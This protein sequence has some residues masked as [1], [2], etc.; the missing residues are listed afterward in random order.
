MAMGG[1]ALPQGKDFA[2]SANLGFFD[3][4]QAVA[5]QAAIRLNEILYFNGG[6]GVGLSD[7]KV[8]GRVG[9]MAAW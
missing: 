6:A 5:A 9:V 7:N 8:G 4:R 3:D 2:L 1:L